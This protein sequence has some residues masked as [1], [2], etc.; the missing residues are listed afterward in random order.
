MTKDQPCAAHEADIDKLR[1]HVRILADLGRL[2]GR[3]FAMDRT[4]LANWLVTP[5]VQQSARCE[6]ARGVG[7]RTKQ[8]HG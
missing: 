4:P 1:R 2:A 7:P 3:D 5:R 8:Q 6:W